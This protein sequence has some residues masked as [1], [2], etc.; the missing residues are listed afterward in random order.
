[1]GSA[2]LVMTHLRQAD[3]AAADAA[4]E[5]LRSDY[6]NHPRLALGAA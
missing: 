4:L 2:G 6:A 1:M 3:Y 5:K